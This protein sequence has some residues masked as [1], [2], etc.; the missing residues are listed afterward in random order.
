[1]DDR[2]ERVLRKD[3]VD[4]TLVEQVDLYAVWCVWGI[5]PAVPFVCLLTW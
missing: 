1:V 3:L 5:Q 2:V 4:I